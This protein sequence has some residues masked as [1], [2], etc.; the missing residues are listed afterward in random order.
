MAGVGLEL[1]KACAIFISAASGYYTYLSIRDEHLKTKTLDEVK[2]DM[3]KVK[4]EA[5]RSSDEYTYQNF[6]TKIRFESIERNITDLNKN[7]EEKS[8]LQ[9]EVEKANTEWSS[10]TNT[11]EKEKLLDYIRIKTLEIRT[12]DTENKKLNAEINK[13]VEAGRKFSDLISKEENESTVMD[14]I[15]DVKKSSMSSILEDFLTKFESLDG[16]SKLA[17][18]VTFSSS[19]IF[20]C[21]LGTILNIYGNYLLERFKLEDRYPKLALIIKYR[22]K[23]SNYYIISNCLVIF[24]L[25]LVNIILGL[26]ILSL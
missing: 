1:K 4:Q 12:I 11:T 9:S 20:W 5:K 19:I 7:Q 17:F 14:K 21:L 3:I 18:V 15:N 2:K 24:S 22:K 25:C 6:Q 26:S 10:A 16:I 23:L 8:K 13:D